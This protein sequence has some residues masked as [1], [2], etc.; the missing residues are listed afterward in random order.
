MTTSIYDADVRARALAPDTSFIVQAPAGSGKTEILSQR[1]LRLLA[2]VSQPEEIIAITFTRKAASEMRARIIAALTEARDQGEPTAA[3]LKQRYQL[4]KMA[5]AQDARQGWD[6]LDNP[7]QL[8]ILTI[9]ALNASL[10]RQMP[11]LARFGA[12]PAVSLEA[13]TLY[14][15]AC[16][17]LIEQLGKATDWQ[18]ALQTLLLHCDNQCEQVVSLC[19]TMLQTRDQWLGH[20]LSAKNDDDLRARLEQGLKRIGDDALAH[21]ENTLPADLTTELWAVARWAGAQSLALE[22]MPSIAHCANLGE[23]PAF[24]SAHFKDWLGIMDL[25]ISPSSG[26]WRKRLTKSQGFPSPSSAPKADQAEYRQQKERMQNLLAAFAEHADFLSALN[27]CRLVPP[28]Q[29]SDKQWPVIEALLTLLP[30]LAAQLQLI[31]AEKGQVDFIEIA[32]AALTALGDDDAPTDVALICDYKIQHLLIDEFQDTSLSQMRLIEKLT[33]GWESGDGR[34]LFLVGD[35]MQSIYR[36]RN[37]QVGLFL[38]TAD[39]G[40]GDIQCESLQLTMNFRSLPA[41]VEWNNQHFPKIFPALEDAASGAIRYA[42][43]Q[44][45][46]SGNDKP[47]VN[48]HVANS[49][50]G[51]AQ[52][53][54]ERIESIRQ[55]QPDAT[56]AVLTRARSHLNDLLAVCND[57]QIPVQAVDLD[58]LFSREAIRDAWTLTKA[59][60]EPA[61]RL[62]NCALLRAP[63]C[64]LNLEDLHA[65]ATVDIKGM[66]GQNL[67]TVIERNSL[68]ADGAARAKRVLV[69]LQDAERTRGKV[70]CADWVA[71]AWHDLQGPICYD[72]P[73]VASDMEAFFHCLREAKHSPIDVDLTLLEQRLSKLFAREVVSDPNPVQIMT[74]HKSKGLEFD[75][76]FLPQCQRRPAQGSHALMRWVERRSL[77][78]HNDL[79][80]A[81]IKSKQD[82]HDPIYT[83][84]NSLDKEKES[85]EQARLFYVATTRAK[86][87]LHISASL[88]TDTPPSSSLLGLLWPHLDSEQIHFIEAEDDGADNLSEQDLSM[89]ARLPASAFSNPIAT[90]PD[91]SQ[92]LTPAWDA[93]D[94][95]PR[96]TG[97]VIHRLLK[98][99]ADDGLEVWQTRDLSAF[100]QNWRQLLNIEGIAEASLEA[101]SDK[102]IAAIGQVLA[103]AR[104]QW[105]LQAHREAVSEYAL[106]TATA[107]GIKQFVVDRSFIDANNTRWI[108][109]YKTTDIEAF[110]DLSPRQQHAYLQQLNHYGDLFAKIS[111]TPIRLGLYF[112]LTDHWHEWAYEPQETLA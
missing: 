69:V 22:G 100:K 21:I 67:K 89:I 40:I 68:S 27:H 77:G 62:A 51:E 2:C 38:Q 76:V 17:R 50:L 36:F 8:R 59:L 105:C 47:A 84:L 41:I 93:V 82:E 104:G 63:W 18:A 4:A 61:D 33:R 90:Q 28:A 79:L 112:P 52:F 57:K 72:D 81:A 58:P 30:I 74:M 20:I 92:A 42:P 25:C 97:I 109:D 11:I 80:L 31:F 87:Q 91:L 24:D 56:I 48:I 3:H 107:D 65:V 85:F 6:L 16:E 55:T 7:Q 73:N 103:S 39:I 88:E 35:P 94:D 78:G 49:A 64:G 14:R 99:I 9:D 70:N 10:T 75:V 102:V 15:Q 106:D 26:S 95:T 60:L 37:A 111:D 43:S 34:T 101:A 86:Q 46:L 1:F 54:A 96:L 19:C 13:D 98:Q 45:A 32:Q 53:I 29:Y 108:I 110:K 23:A 44:P 5:L 83:Y 66:I 12:E 71:K